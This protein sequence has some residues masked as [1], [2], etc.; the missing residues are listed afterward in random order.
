MDSNPA[1]FSRE[2]DKECQYM[3]A[4]AAEEPGQPQ[5]PGPQAA[6]GAAGPGCPGPTQDSSSQIIKLRDYPDCTVSGGIDWF[7]W[8]GLVDFSQSASF[9]SMCREFQLGKEYCQ[10]EKRAYYQT[11]VPEFGPVRVR[12]I[13]VNRGGDRGQHFEYRVNVP[14]A[15]YGVSPRTGD[16]LSRGKSRQQANFYVLQTGRDCLLHGAQQGYDRALHFLTALGGSPRELKISRGDLCLDVCNL[17]T[18]DLLKLVE[19]GHFVTLARNVHPNINYVM[20]KVTGFVAGKSPIRLSVYDKIAERMGKA[21]ALYLRALI[22]RRWYG[23]TDL[24]AA[25]RIE[26]QM[27]RRW[28]SEKGITSPQEFIAQRGTLCEELTHNWFRLTGKRVD[29]RNKHQSRAQTHRIWEGI[30]QGFLDVF[31]KPEGRLAPIRRDKVSPTKLSEQGRGC[32]ANALLQM[33]M[34]FV[35]YGEF[36]EM[37][38]RLILAMPASKAQ[39]DAFMEELGRRKMEFETS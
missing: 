31:G 38:K 13:G 4:A 25:S 22:D 39:A 32:F 37:C 2:D 17:R 9:V 16:E 5:G 34:P 28:L 12:R 29:R 6:S 20:D 11:F 26:Y 1:Q 15:T 21:D 27:S 30:Q 18:E 24:D 10:A 33:D 14:G 3:P 19:A 7:E 23:V 8:T 36:A 35:T